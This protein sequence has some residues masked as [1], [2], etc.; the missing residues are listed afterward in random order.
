MLEGKVVVLGVTGSIAAYKI[1]NL[2]SML[3]KQ[4]CQVHVIMTKNAVNFINP[5]TFE[6]LTGNKCLVDTFDRNFQFHVAHVSLAKKAD[7]ILIAPASANVIGKVANGIADDMLTTTVMACPGKVM[8][9]PAM[10]VNMYQNPILQH[11]LDILRN[12]GYEIIDPAV[13]YL[14]CGDTGSGKMP[15]PETLMEYIVRELA[16]KKD[17]K[18]RRILV[19]AGP[20]RESID[21]VRY[22]TNHSTGKMGYAVARRAMLR[23]ADVTL[24]SGPTLLKEVPFIKK[25]DIISAQDMFEAVRENL[26]GQDFLVKAAAVADYTPGVVSDEKVKK[27]DG[28]MVIELKRTRDILGYVAEHKEEGQIICGFSMETQNML[29]NSRKKLDKKKLDIIVANNLKVKGAGFG[30]DTNVVTLITAEEEISLDIMS[31]EDVADA[32]L[33]QLLRLSK[34]RQKGE[35]A[36]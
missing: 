20:T 25:V 2:A 35:P 1:P 33:D 24:I 12:Y 22:I 15:E 17:L 10:N 21:P 30:T 14:A 5:V 18:G 16:C 34:T 7:L 19:T 8:F 28:D 32:I 11:N 4:H 13:G 6:T 27:K 23:G 31:K 36:D 26:P 9:S 29:E 3:V